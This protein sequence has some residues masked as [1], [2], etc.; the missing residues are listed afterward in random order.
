MGET[1][2]NLFSLPRAIL[3]VMS[4]CICFSATFLAMR[5]GKMPLEQ[6]F[7]N[8]AWNSS[9]SFANVSHALMAVQVRNHACFLCMPSTFFPCIQCSMMPLTSVLAC[10]SPLARYTGNLYPIRRIFNQSEGLEKRRPLQRKDN[11][12]NLET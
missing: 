11:Q 4:M 10:L 2:G 1:G 12:P 3:L 5:F 7:D 6:A 8:F 9:L